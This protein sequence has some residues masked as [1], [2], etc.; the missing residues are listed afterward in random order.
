MRGEVDGRHLN[1][2]KLTVAGMSVDQFFLELYH[3]AAEML[4]EQPDCELVNVDGSIE[5]D[6][7]NLEQSPE[8]NRCY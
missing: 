6:E 7:L 8:T 4:P 5:K 2:R 1:G 3:S